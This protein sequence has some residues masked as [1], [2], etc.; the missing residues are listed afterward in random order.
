MTY[1]I[2]FQYMGPDDAR[3]QDYVQEG[4]LIF[5]NGEFVPIPAVGDSVHCNL[6]GEG[7]S[8]RVVSRH[9]TYLNMNP[10]EIDWCVVNIVVTDL[11]P[12][13]M[14]KRLKE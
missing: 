5:K 12:G 4:E 3:P 11:L 8:F 6:N 13:E 10:P 9:F 14:A 2:E 1:K 7:G